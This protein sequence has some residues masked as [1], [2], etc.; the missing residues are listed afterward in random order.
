MSLGVFAAAA[1]AVAVIWLEDVPGAAA[2]T[3]SVQCLSNWAWAYNSRQQSPCLVAAYLVGQCNGGTFNID[4]LAV[5]THYTGPTAAD[6]TPCQCSTVTYSLISAC[7]A[8]QNRTVETWSAWKTNCSTVYITALPDGINIPSGTSVPSWAYLDV[9]TTDNFS[10]AAAEA[11]LSSP[12]STGISSQS[13]ATSPKSTAAGS[14]ASSTATGLSDST[15]TAS[16]KKSSNTGAI[17]GGVVGGVVGAALIAAIVAFFLIRRRRAQTAPSAAFTGGPNHLMSP[18]PKAE[19]YADNNSLPPVTPFPPP[20]ETAMSQPRLYDPSD[21]STFPVPAPS[22]SMQT[23]N[24]GYTGYNGSGNGYP[25]STAS[26]VPRG[27][28]SGAPEV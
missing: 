26:P 12:E 13:T 20:S 28:Y 14:T 21:P 8:C 11:D 3:S 22:P 19:Y 16:S 5:G 9:T 23:G 17:A 6:V 1:A 18:P 24:S 15:P 4:P 2:Q 25:H 7:G 27:Q 10:P